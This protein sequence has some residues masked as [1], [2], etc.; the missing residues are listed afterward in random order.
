MEP[1]ASSALSLLNDAKRETESIAY[2]RPALEILQEVQR[3]GDIFFPTNWTRA[4]LSGHHSAEAKHEVDRFF[5][6][7]PDYSP[8]LSNKIRQQADHL[9]LK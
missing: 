5:A 8:M 3:T 2:I 4:L 1:W 9:Y 7:H 6:D